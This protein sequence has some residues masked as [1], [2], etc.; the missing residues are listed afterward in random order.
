MGFIEALS[1]SRSIARTNEL[2]RAS[3]WYRQEMKSRKP[4]VKTP[5]GSRG[6]SL[7]IEPV[8]TDWHAKDIHSSIIE[9][10]NQSNPNDNVL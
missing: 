3:Y 4:E 6:Q 9:S 7:K 2:E 5:V 10:N 8:N 1:Q